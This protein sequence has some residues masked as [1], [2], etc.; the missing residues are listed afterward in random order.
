MKVVVDY[1]SVGEEAAV[2]GRSLGDRGRGARAAHAR[3]PRALRARPSHCGARRPR[4]H[5]LRGRAGRRH[6]PPAASTASATLGRYIEYGASPRGPIGLVQAAR[7]LAL[8]RGRGHVVDRRRARPR[9]RRAAPPPRALLRR[10]GRRRERRRPARAGARPSSA[11]PPGDDR[12]RRTRGRVSR[13][14]S[15]HA[16]RGPP[17]PR[18]DAARARRRARP[19]G[20]APAPAGALPGDRRAAGLGPGTELAQL[21][22]YE[23]GDDVRQID[24]AGDARAPACRTC[25]CTCPSATL[26]TWVVLDVSPSMAFGTAER[27]KSD[28]AE[29]VATVARR[30]SRSAAPGASRSLRFGGGGLRL[31]PPRAS[32]RASWRCAAR[33]RSRRRRRRRPATRAALADA[34]V[35]VGRSRAS[36]GSSSSSPTSATRRLDARRSARCATRHSVLAVE[37]ARPARGRAARRRAPRPRRPRDRAT[38]S[39]STPRAAGCASA[40]PPPR[41]ERRERGR[42][43]SCGA[44]R[45]DHVALSTEGDWLREL[46]AGCCDELRGPHLPARAGCS[47]PLVARRAGRARRR[48]ARRYAV[49]FPAAADAQPRPRR[50]PRWRRAS[51][52]RAR[53]RRALAA[54]VVAMAKPQRTVAVPVERASVMLVTDHS[55]SMLATDVE[56]V[57]LA[58]AQS[59]A[60]AFLD[61][62]PEPAAGRHRRVLRRARRASRPPTPTTTRRA[63]ADRRAGRRRRDRDRRR[64]AGA[65]STARCPPRQHGK[66]RRRRSSC[67]PTASDDDGSDPLAVAREAKR[68]SIP[69]YTVALGTVGRHVPNPRLRPAALRP[70]G[71]ETLQQI[72][73]ASGGSAFTA[74][75][76][77][78]SSTRSTRTL[79]SQLGTK[80]TQARGHGRLRGRRRPAAARRGGRLAALDRPAAVGPRKRARAA[81]LSGRGRRTVACPPCA[82]TSSSCSAPRG[83]RL[84]EPRARGRRRPA[85]RRR[86]RRGPT[87]GRRRRARRAAGG[88]RS[89]C[90]PRPFLAA[91]GSP[92]V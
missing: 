24:A 7:A 26:T 8:L 86:G 45:V 19:R 72:A 16:A 46:G 14:P 42:R 4:R 81:E 41:R 35:R 5:R 13:T 15:L 25:A 44:L 18:P 32:G 23:V 28:V 3:G 85:S 51:A 1:P 66:R 48:R 22:P 6:A 10:A 38:A 87:G 69:I 62:V 59:A 89:S 74:E 2:V 36:P 73:A 78:R 65:R 55:R 43:A 68:C 9:R 33:S 34:L 79:G 40:S 63:A 17:G 80:R 29:G 76:A 20:R 31:L 60:R 52:R 11:E 64:A 57:R 53:A 77:D 27:L 75:D 58:A 39:R 67:S 47:I 83:D 82:T 84:G 61:R 21:R 91:A 92:S 50:A 88:R 54:L 49:R 56:P 71:P 37:V 90:G 30:A 12:S 70:A